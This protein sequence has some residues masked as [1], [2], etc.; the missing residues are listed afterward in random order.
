MSN[1]II[2]K[3]DLEDNFYSKEEAESIIKSSLKDALTDYFYS[4]E[5]KKQL[6]QEVVS[7]YVVDNFSAE[8]QVKSREI[9][10]SLSKSDVFGYSC[11]NLIARESI[12]P[13]MKQE[14][15]LISTKMCEIIGKL[16]ETDLKE[17]LIEYINKKLQ[18]N[19]KLDITAKYK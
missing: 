4:S 11:D 8:L 9:I 19:I 7:K 16:D 15:T 12:F 6:T 2:V 5:F 18:E 13:I 14:T 17:A 1:E 10:K 3:L